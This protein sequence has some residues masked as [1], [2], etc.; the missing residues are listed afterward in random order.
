MGSILKRKLRNLLIAVLTVAMVLPNMTVFAIELTEGNTAPKISMP[1]PYSSSYTNVTDGRY[2][3][4]PNYNGKPIV[5]DFVTYDD[6]QVVTTAGANC[7][8]GEYLDELVAYQNEWDALCP[9]N[10]PL[11]DYCTT[12]PNEISRLHTIATNFLNC[13]SRTY[14]DETSIKTIVDEFALL[15]DEDFASNYD[16]YMSNICSAILSLGDVNLEDYKLYKDGYYLLAY[17]RV[18]HS[19][20]SETHESISISDELVI[21]RTKLKPIW[22][23]KTVQYKT[24]DEM[25]EGELYLPGSIIFS[26]GNYIPFIYTPY[27]VSG[28]NTLYQNLGEAILE[29]Y[30]SS[31]Y[32]G[33]KVYLT[34]LQMTKLPDTYAGIPVQYWKLEESIT[35]REHIDTYGNG[36]SVT[37]D[38]G[39]TVE[40][41]TVHISTHYSTEIYKVKFLKMSPVLNPSTE[42]L[43]YMDYFTGAL[44][45]SDTI[46]ENSQP[47]LWNGNGEYAAWYDSSG[48]RVEE[49]SLQGGMILYGIPYELNVNITDAF[50]VFCS[51][52]YPYEPP[53]SEE[54]SWKLSDEADLNDLNNAIYNLNRTNYFNP[55]AFPVWSSG[56][57]LYGVNQFSAT[58]LASIYTSNILMYPRDISA[59]LF[60]GKDGTEITTAE[61]VSWRLNSING[62][63]VDSADLYGEFSG[64]DNIVYALN[65][66]ESDKAQ[67]PIILSLSP[68]FYKDDV[69]DKID[70]TKLN[71]SQ[72]TY[73]SY[74]PYTSRTLIAAETVMVSPTCTMDGSE[75]YSV[76]YQFDNIGFLETYDDFFKT[77]STFN[78]SSQQSL[79][80]VTSM[81]VHEASYYDTVLCLN[82]IESF[83]EFCNPYLLSEYG[84]RQYESVYLFGYSPEYEMYFEFYPDYSNG[85]VEFVVHYNNNYNGYPDYNAYYENWDYEYRFT[86][87]ANGVAAYNAWVNTLPIAFN[88]EHA[89]TFDCDY[90]GIAN[91]DN[92]IQTLPDSSSESLCNNAQFVLT[93]Q[94][95]NTSTFESA[96][97]RNN[98]NDSVYF[99]D[100]Y[101]NYY[102]PFENEK[103]I[104]KLGHMYGEEW[105]E[106]DIDEPTT[107]SEITTINPSVV[108]ADTLLL[109]S[110]TDIDLSSVSSN[111][112]MAY[113]ICDR[114]QDAYELTTYH[115]HSYGSPE[116]IWA[117]D[118]SSCEAVFICVN[119]D[120]TQEVDCTISSE[121][122]EAKCEIDGEASYVAT[123][124]FESN[125]YTDTKVEVLPALGH[126]YGEWYEVTRA[127][128]ESEGEKRRDCIRNDAFETDVIPRLS[129]LVV[130]YNGNGGTP[131]R[132]S[133]EKNY[134][135]PYGD[136]SSASKK[137]YTL[138]GWTYNDG[139]NILDI[140]S[141]SIV[142]VQGDHTLD[143]KWSPIQY[144]IVFNNTGTSGE[145]SELD[146]IYDVEYTL[147]NNAFSNNK[148][149]TL[150]FDD[151]VTPKETN[152][153]TASFLGWSN[154]SQSDT[155]AYTDKSSVKNLCEENDGKVNL[156]TVWD[157]ITYTLPVPERENYT[158]I[159]W[160]DGTSTHNCGEK[161]TVLSD[162]TLTAQWVK[163]TGT[164][165]FNP[166]DGECDIDS[167]SVSS[168]DAYGEL[169]TATL[170]NH[171]FLGW[172]TEIIDGTQITSESIKENADDETLYAHYYEKDYI[173]TFDA[174]GGSCDI[175]SKTIRNGEAYGSL[176]TPTKDNH[177]FLGWFTSVDGDV[178]IIADAV[179]SSSGDETVYAH[180][181]ELPYVLTFDANGGNCD[182]TSK[183]VE[184]GKPYGELPTPT[185]ED[186]TFLGWFTSIDG[187]I[188]MTAESVKASSGNETVYAR[189]YEKDYILT[190]DANGGEC[191]ITTKIIRNGEMY[192]ELPIPTQENYEFLGWFTSLEEGVKI[193]SDTIKTLS[194]DET[195]YAH[196]QREPFTIN[197]EL[198]GGTMVPEISLLQAMDESENKPFSKKVR[199]GEAYGTLP[200]VV[201]TGYSF[202][203]WFTGLEDGDLIIETTIKSTEKDETLYAHWENNKYKVSFDANGGQCG[204]ASKDVLYDEAYGDLP[205]PTRT[206]H[207]F[208]GWFTQKEDGVEITKDS[209]KTT[210]ADEILYARWKEHQYTIKFDANGGK[211]EMLD[212]TLLFTE[213]KTLNRNMFTK[214]NHT[215]IGWNID[216]ETQV[217]KYTDEET[218]SGLISVDGGTIVL[219]AIWEKEATKPTPKPNPKP[220]PTPT[221]TPTPTPVPTQCVVPVKPSKVS[222]IPENVQTGDDFSSAPYLLVFI[223]G[224]S[225]VL[226]SLVIIIKRKKD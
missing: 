150:D 143:A 116:F 8:T 189:W 125:T 30:T 85:D 120:D 60:D 110:E 50:S 68:Y 209:I 187:G 10:V 14:N 20:G 27:G 127:T 130:A 112:V 79:T 18:N 5:P 215:F 38:W 102:V 152:A 69:F 224:C 25:I 161:I 122:S 198:N 148:V 41:G 76:S 138:T 145:M 171:T 53:Y 92:V 73:N 43:F 80:N 33:N 204:V 71:W 191:D 205:I 47:S 118:Y 63:A 19:Y 61:P 115:K 93:K 166:V 181:K 129:K 111:D 87:D 220:D 170:E 49:G 12:N 176:P 39:N 51:N 156:Y 219:Y 146:A 222:D 131:E 172:F 177:E 74:N 67:H 86:N 182:V 194:G 173:L 158:C 17:E 64:E 96:F 113:R 109:Y 226:S 169:P 190:F 126:E 211:G 144:G 163:T 117:E 193:K 133:D 9:T 23:P 48:N 162:I 175:A 106:F 65:I 55:A 201:K 216:S 153:L 11:I 183:Q 200:T 155:I 95:D 142:S 7:P 157:E 3:Y 89:L 114:M 40:N 121:T 225:M 99:I 154:D 197:F 164:V 26:T 24:V 35:E 46:Q 160:S 134:N 223:L 207:T 44:V 4:N 37:G 210:D 58:T 59:T 66:S 195:V 178:Q 2:S 140:T 165:Y 217:V 180:W 45:Y 36:I 221:P 21:E 159:G 123:A 57:Y 179:K 84:S 107:Y 139:I 218:V 54:S 192:G 136:L 56:S 98:G 31:S 16:T 135:Q 52:S 137:G 174:N 185:R 184:V 75:G 101:H 82:E 203:G 29:E 132:T 77:D 213:S 147:P 206:G 42:D 168:G 103:A 22:G 6:M 13:L 88:G 72:I 151:G 188:E 94:E 32:Y 108:D 90:M 62:L 119:N 78:W 167:K 28:S 1:Y 91:R 104:D 15:S 81:F 149:L 141:E 105:V 100:A 208:V 83:D 124:E 128:Y 97:M 214:N 202:S 186:Y 70:N 212:M 199:Y 34:G 196:W